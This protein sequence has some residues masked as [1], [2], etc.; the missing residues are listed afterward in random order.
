MNLEL[1]D[2]EREFLLSLLQDRLGE[3]KEEIHHSR[4]ADFTAQLKTMEQCVRGLIG[5]LDTKSS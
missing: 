5:K 3:L 2:V 1:T 4:V